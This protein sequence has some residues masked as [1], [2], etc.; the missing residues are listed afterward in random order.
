M[1]TMPSIFRRFLTLVA[2]LGCL[3]AFSPLVASPLVHAGSVPP[4]TVISVPVG[5]EGKE[6]GGG[7]SSAL[8]GRDRTAC[9]HASSPTI[10][11]LLCQ[12]HDKEPGV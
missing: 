7:G 5:N 12:D 10:G 6:S 2:A 11:G 4:G 8:G 1:K 3:S 9:L